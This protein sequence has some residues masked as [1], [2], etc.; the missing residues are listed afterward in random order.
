LHARAFARIGVD[1]QKIMENL[2]E[3][4]FSLV[5]DSNGLIDITYV[6]LENNRIKLDLNFVTN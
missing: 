5:I 4:M 3:N 2:L 1:Y 6:A